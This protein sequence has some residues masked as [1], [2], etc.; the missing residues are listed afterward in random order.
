MIGQDSAHGTRADGRALV[1]TGAAFVTEAHVECRNGGGTWWHFACP[2][3]GGASA[4][5]VLRARRREG[6]RLDAL[7]GLF[8]GMGTADEDLVG[9]LGAP[10]D[11]SATTAERYALYRARRRRMEQPELA[12]WCDVRELDRVLGAFARRGDVTHDLVPATYC[13]LLAMMQALQ[14]DFETRVVLWFDTP[15]GH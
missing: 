3:V 11:L 15:A 9:A 7:A 14:R 4:S 13:A 5:D 12:T 10:S 6:A 2:A 1:P 8:L